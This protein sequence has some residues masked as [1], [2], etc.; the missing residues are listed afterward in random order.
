[1]AYILIVDE[2]YLSAEI[3]S[4]ALVQAGHTSGTVHDAQSARSLLAH[5]RPDLLLISAS[6]PGRSSAGL[7]RELRLSDEYHQLPI[8]LLGLQSA[9]LPS[10]QEVL[11]KPT[12][13]AVL[14]G[15]VN[16]ILHAAGRPVHHWQATR[17]SARRA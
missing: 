7:M 4:D 15:R 2:D 12:M 17:S 9:M 1:M 14:V 6:L 11:P 16:A 8:I 13:P 10:A 5:K 3:A